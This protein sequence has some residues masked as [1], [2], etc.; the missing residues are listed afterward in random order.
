[1]TRPITVGVDGSPQ[2]RAAAEWAAREAARRGLPLHLVHAWINEPLYAPPVPDEPASRQLL[3]DHH[4]EVADRHPG[5]TISTALLGEM[6]TA[7]LVEQAARSELLVMG[8]R[9]HGP[10]AGF[11][12]GSVGLPVITHSTRPVVLVRSG[13]YGEPTDQAPGEAAEGDEIVVGLKDMGEPAAAL[14]E[15]AF[16]TAS[17]RGAAVRAVR[18]WGTPSLFGS[19]P[20]ENLENNDEHLDL[21]ARQGEEL[22]RVLAPWRQ[23][24]P[25]VPVIEHLRYGNAAEVL[26]DAASVHAALVVTGRRTRR[27]LLAMRAGPVTHAA[28]HHARTPVAVVPHGD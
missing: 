15:F 14:L 8:S 16:T 28:L 10:I 23:R 1:M 20:P 21:Q 7:G 9:G 12:L 27:P 5:L 22:V 11:L 25:G 24:Y 18:A 4:D 3:Q 19:T 26:L 2:S 17:A 13:P 6:A